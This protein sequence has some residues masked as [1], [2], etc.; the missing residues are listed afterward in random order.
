MAVSFPLPSILTI[1]ENPVQKSGWLCYTTVQKRKISLV[2]PTSP[3]RGHRM[4]TQPHSGP[5]QGEALSR[6]FRQEQ[7]LPGHEGITE[8]QLDVVWRNRNV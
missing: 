8:L 2:G 6:S 1:R 4:C 7:Q 5:D 3:S